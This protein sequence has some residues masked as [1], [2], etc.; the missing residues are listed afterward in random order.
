MCDTYQQDS[1]SYIKVKSI[2]LY[3]IYVLGN[4][5]KETC[6]LAIFYEFLLTVI[7]FTV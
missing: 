6:H 3:S 2:E 1:I 4:K 5:T 7:R